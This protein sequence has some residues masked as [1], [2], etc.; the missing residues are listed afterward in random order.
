MET[1]D[2]GP[3]H[4]RVKEGLPRCRRLA[5]NIKEV[6]REA[7]GHGGDALLVE[8]QALDQGGGEA[9]LVLPGPVYRMVSLRRRSIV[10]AVRYALGVAP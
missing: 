1:S 2:R 4:L 8:F 9:G 10:P 3:S 6:L 5:Q 7:I